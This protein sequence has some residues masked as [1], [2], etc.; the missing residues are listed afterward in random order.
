MLMDALFD[1]FGLELSDF[2]KQQ[3]ERY[4]ELLLEWNQKFN[5]TAITEPEDVW[6]KHFLDSLLITRAQAW[7]GKG[8]VADLGSGAGF[9]GIPLKILCPDLQVVLFEAS[10]K[11]TEFLNMVCMALGLENIKAVHLR[12]EDAGQSKLYRETFDWVVSR[13]VASLSV[14]AE[15]GLPLLKINGILA[16]YKGP[17]YLQELED[18]S[19]ALKTLGGT[20]MGAESAELPKN[21]GHRH[22]VLIQKTSPTPAAY[23]RK[24]GMPGRKPL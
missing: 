11:K 10:A 8:L 23:P 17:G 13:A 7:Q 5:L 18:A 20:L 14:L 1:H 15:Y 2:Q 22:I 9:P 12:A 6:I 19:R 3:F 4:L 24:A 21:L 16:A